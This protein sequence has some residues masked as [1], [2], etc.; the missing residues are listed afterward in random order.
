MILMIW[1]KFLKVNNQK[2]FIYQHYVVY[3]QKDDF[4]NIRQVK[5]G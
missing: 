1:R 3:L 2:Y 5:K 4:F